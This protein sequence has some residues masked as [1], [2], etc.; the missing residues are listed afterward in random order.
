MKTNQA[1]IMEMTGKEDVISGVEFI[2]Y[3]FRYITVNAYV[4]KIYSYVGMTLSIDFSNGFHPEE[5]CN[6]ERDFK[7][8]QL[9]LLKACTAIHEVEISR[10]TE[11]HGEYDYQELLEKEVVINEI[12]ENKD[13]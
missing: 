1:L 3:A 5:M 11:E 9:A 12:K 2:G 6:N 10:E 8:V 4:F 13:V 7:E